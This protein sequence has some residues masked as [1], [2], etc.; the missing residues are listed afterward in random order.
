MEKAAALKRVWPSQ[1]AAIGALVLQNASPREAR[2]AA[3]ATFAA[4]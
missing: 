4:R 3:R 2:A 1:A